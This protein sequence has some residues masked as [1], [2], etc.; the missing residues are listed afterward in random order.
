M[1]SFVKSQLKSLNDDA[2][3]NEFGFLI[4]VMC[5]WG[6]G[7]DLLESISDHLQDSL[8]TLTTNQMAETL[9]RSR[10]GIEINYTMHTLERTHPSIN[11]LKIG[12]EKKRVSFDRLSHEKPLL[13]LRYLAYILQHPYNKKIILRQNL[14]Q[15]FTNFDLHSISILFSTTEYFIFY[16]Y[17]WNNFVRV[18][19]LS[20]K[21]SKLVQRN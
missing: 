7:E 16:S 17:R 10:R 18:W 11:F 5:N 14:L 20:R 12:T 21:L 4:D 2:M 13:G 9:R 15:V 19:R 1:L 3:P 6:R 8:N